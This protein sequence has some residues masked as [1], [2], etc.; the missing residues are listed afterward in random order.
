VISNPWQRLLAVVLLLSS[1]AVFCGGCGSSEL[2]RDTVQQVR[3]AL[4]SD[5]SE[6][7]LLLDAVPS[8]VGAFLE[9]HS[10]ALADDARA[11]AEVLTSP[12]AAD[13]RIRVKRLQTDA[14]RLAVALD[15]FSGSLGS[16]ELTALS[17]EVTALLDDINR[18]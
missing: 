2:T 6:A 14:Q 16:S 3:D 4:R 11:Q 18:A 1:L 8:T 15:H 13:Q 12:A 5:A 7:R 10:A 17:V 9:Q